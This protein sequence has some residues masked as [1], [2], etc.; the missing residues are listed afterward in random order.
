MRTNSNIK[1]GVVRSEPTSCFLEA[2]KSSVNRFISIAYFGTWA[3]CKM[4]CVSFEDVQG[5]A[6]C[7]SMTVLS[8][9]DLYICTGSS[10]FYNSF[11]EIVELGPFM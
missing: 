2:L 9:I 10:T 3:Y 8:S 5:V 1:I 7:L 6:F 4:G 11:M